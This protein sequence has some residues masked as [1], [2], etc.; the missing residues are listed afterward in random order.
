DDGGDSTAAP[1]ASS[2]NIGSNRVNI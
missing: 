1:L 2:S